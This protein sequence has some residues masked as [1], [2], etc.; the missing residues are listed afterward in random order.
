M[1]RVYSAIHCRHLLIALISKNKVN[2]L[3]KDVALSSAF[4]RILLGIMLC[5]NASVS[6]DTITHQSEQGLVFPK[7]YTFTSKTIEYD[8]KIITNSLGIRDRE[9]SVD[10]ED[11]YRI[12]CFRNSWTMGF[13]VNIENSWPRKLQEYLQANQFRNV[14]VVNCGRGGRYTTKYFR[15]HE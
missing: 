11:K 4:I 1:D 13:G 2:K 8:Y 15:V 10:K 6:D 7:N 12:L 5:I 3:L 9:I 14:E